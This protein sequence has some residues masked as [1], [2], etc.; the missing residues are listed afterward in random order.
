MRIDV[1]LFKS[2]LAR[3]RTEAKNLISEGAVSVNGRVVEKPALD[4]DVDNDEIMVREGVNPFVSR[5]GF[6]LAQALR[7]FDI[8][9]EGRR[10]LDIGASSGGFTDCLLQ[11]GATS[12][13]ALDSGRDQIAASLREDSRV[14]VVEGYNARYIKASD[15]DYIPTLAV[16]DVSFISATYIIPPL[17]EV[18]PIGADFICLIKPQFEVG[19]GG[20]GK[21]GIV[22][23]EKE[24]RRA[25][26]R[27]TES[28]RLSGF[29][30]LGVIQS[31]IR[32]GDG[33]VE[34]LAHFRKN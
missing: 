7:V 18:L 2:G 12:V 4:I 3:S 24:R 17:S 1:Y 5:G 6:K 29:S 22:K 14:Q 23:D 11:S 32:G 28:A 20:I 30:C 19:K 31:P 9:V 13:I 10:C 33:N 15:F 16:M 27:V 21:G 8:N 34:Y 26:D 25:I